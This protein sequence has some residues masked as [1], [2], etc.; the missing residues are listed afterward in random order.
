MTR[1]VFILRFSPFLRCTCSKPTGM[2][3]LRRGRAIFGGSGSAGASQGAVLACADRLA[4][5]CGAPAGALVRLL[6]PPG[7]N[8]DGKDETGMPMQ[9]LTRQ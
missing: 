3:T 6:R 2:S 8:Q 5:L 4:A 9:H 1:R 7:W